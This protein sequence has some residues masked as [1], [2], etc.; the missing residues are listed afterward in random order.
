MWLVR[1]PDLTLNLLF[2][3]ELSVLAY[4]TVSALN[5]T[6]NGCLSIAVVPVISDHLPYER[7]LWPGGS[8]SDLGGKYNIQCPMLNVQWPSVLKTGLDS[9]VDASRVLSCVSWGL[10]SE[11]LNREPVNPERSSL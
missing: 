7:P 9:Y 5:M 11:P 2:R 3:Q 8:Q 6:H 10:N 1:I 4:E